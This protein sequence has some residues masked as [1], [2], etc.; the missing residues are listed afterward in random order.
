VLGALVGPLVLPDAPTGLQ[1]G[2]LLL[3]LIPV[4]RL[5]PN[6]VFALLRWLPYA[7]AALYFL[8]RTRVALIDYPL[9]Y[10]L[11]LLTTAIAGAALLLSLLLSKQ[12]AQNVQVVPLLRH[13]IN[14]AGWVAV[15]GLLVACVANLFGNVSLAETLTK[16]VLESGYLALAIFGGVTAVLTLL[17]FL[18]TRGGSAQST[19][20]SRYLP[21]LTRALRKAVVFGALILWIAVTADDFQLYD[22]AVEWFTNVLTYRLEIGRLTLTLGGVLLFVA[23][24]WIALLIAKAVRFVLHNDVLS[25]MSLPAGVATSVSSLTYYLLVFV[26]IL[27]ALAASGFEVSQLTLIIGALGVGIGLGLQNVV[28]NFVSGLILMFERPIRPGDVVDTAGVTGRVLSIGMRA[29]TLQTFEGAE[30]VVPNDSMLSNNITNWTLLNTNRRV[31]LDIGV[32]YS[33][34]PATVQRLLTQVAKSVPG[35]STSPEP[36]ALFL[37]FNQ[38]SLDFGIR[39]WTNDFNNWRAIQ[40]EL[41]VKVHAALKDAGIEIPYP[42]HDLHLR[43]VSPQAR[44]NLAGV[45]RAEPQELERR[46]RPGV[47]T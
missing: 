2:A 14:W 13:A 40:S 16:G 22:P 41:A 28:A 23:S 25:R 12:R 20:A 27:A 37:R 34:D 36:V 1:Q 24:A 31:D 30:V 8:H 38:S 11:H 29:T 7:I 6:E 46:A 39:A 33:A 21:T 43:S 5:L 35:I 45:E 26:G 18:L 44:A 9:L 47:G 32:A 3:G 15:G 19:L 17:A 10:R 4:L 42:Q